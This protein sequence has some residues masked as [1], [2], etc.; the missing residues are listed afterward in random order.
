MAIRLAGILQTRSGSDETPE[1]QEE[2]SLLARLLELEE[3]EQT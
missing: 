2:G 3:K 1:Q